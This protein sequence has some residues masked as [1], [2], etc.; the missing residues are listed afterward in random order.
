MNH[1][2]KFCNLVH[3]DQQQQKQQQQHYSNTLQSSSGRSTWQVY[4]N[5]YSY[6]AQQRQYN[7]NLS[8][9]DTLLWDRT[10]CLRNKTETTVKT[11]HRVAAAATALC[12]HVKLTS[13]WLRRHLNHHRICLHWKKRRKCPT[14]KHHDP[15]L[16][17]RTPTSE[18]QQ[19]ICSPT[20]S[21]S[22]MSI[23]QID[24][25]LCVRIDVWKE[26]T[27]KRK[28]HPPQGDD[29]STV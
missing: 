20:Q 28:Q 16:E 23:Y 2:N 29:A 1:S 24:M 9:Q 26:L 7:R 10:R 22:Y 12:M 18:W 8:G 15:G 19:P 11:T 27:Q 17:P 6:V 3:D 5:T 13:R 25:Y 14:K 4:T 21:C